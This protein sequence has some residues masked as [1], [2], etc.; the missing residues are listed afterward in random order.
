M[1]TNMMYYISIYT[2]YVN[3]NFLRKIWAECLHHE[4]SGSAADQESSAVTADI[5]SQL[6]A[7]LKRLREPVLEQLLEVLE[8]RGQYLGPCCE[9]PN[10]R[11]GKCFF[12][13]IMSVCDAM[14]QIKYLR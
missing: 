7:V 4:S 2:Y 8:R 13:I 3:L 6:S 11:L 14:G 10:T 1:S 9:I 5:R 12:H